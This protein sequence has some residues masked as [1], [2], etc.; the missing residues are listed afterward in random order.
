MNWLVVSLVILGVVAALYGLHRL[1]LWAESRGW[2]YYRT[3]PERGRGFGEINRI[4]MLYDPSVEHIVEE[5]IVGEYRHVD[6]E[7]GQGGPDEDE[8]SP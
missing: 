2:I 6:D 7:D 8:A 3:K 4:L 5:R 1:A